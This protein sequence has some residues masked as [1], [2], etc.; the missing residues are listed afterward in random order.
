V[1]AGHSGQT[2]TV[3]DSIGNTYHQAVLLNI[4]VDTPNGD[5]LAIF[6][7]ENILGGANT[8]TVSDTISGILRFAILEYAGVATSN[9]LDVTASAQGTSASPNSGN[10]TTTAN[11][12]LLLGAIAT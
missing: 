11:G 3:T 5:T 7:A 2:F 10:A 1:R 4:T 6:Y 8:I 9:S 12:D